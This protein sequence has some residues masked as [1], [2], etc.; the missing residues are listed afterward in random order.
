[1][2]IHPLQVKAFVE[3]PNAATAQQYLSEV[4]NWA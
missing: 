1:V 3:K 4:T 2:A